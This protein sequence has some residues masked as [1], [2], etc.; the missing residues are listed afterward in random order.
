MQHKWIK[1]GVNPQDLQI[2]WEPVSKWLFDL[3]PQKA[4]DKECNN[5]LLCHHIRSFQGN[6]KCEAKCYLSV[7]GT[8][9]TLDYTDKRV[10]SFNEKQDICIGKCKILFASHD[11]KLI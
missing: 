5:S 6:E 4:F 1:N 8:I 7:K 11:R 10:L 9:A 2:R 3:I